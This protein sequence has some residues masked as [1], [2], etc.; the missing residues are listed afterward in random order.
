M[1][2]RGRRRKTAMFSK[3]SL[4]ARYVIGAALPY[5]FLSVAL[6]TAILLAQQS[7]RFAELA[8]YTQLP[9]SLF[10]EIE[11]ALVQCPGFHVTYGGSGGRDDRFRPHGKR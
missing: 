2:Q 11:I 7:E 4:I 8:L 6:L 3:R 5:F 10:G 1:G 9:F